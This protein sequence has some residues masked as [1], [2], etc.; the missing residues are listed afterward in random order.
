MNSE[1]TQRELA[2]KQAFYAAVEAVA[3]DEQDI[4]AV[5]DF[6]EEFRKQGI[7]TEQ[8]EQVLGLLSQRGDDWVYESEAAWILDCGVDHL[9]ESKKVAIQ[10]ISDALRLPRDY[11]VELL[12]VED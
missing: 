10:N 7:I 9:T 3:K 6:L 4:E 2:V 12:K 5:G 1:Q 8:Q 11:I